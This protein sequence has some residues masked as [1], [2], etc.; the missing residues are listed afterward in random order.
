MT[1]EFFLNEI[2]NLKQEQAHL[3]LRIAKFNDKTP[4]RLKD[5]LEKEYIGL[6]KIIADRESQLKS[7]RY[8][9]L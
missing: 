3:K 2:R 8:D 4:Q 6:S 7:E 1:R 9:I 5:A